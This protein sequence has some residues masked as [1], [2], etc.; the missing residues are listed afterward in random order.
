M[1]ACR[2]AKCLLL[3][4]ISSGRREGMRAERT[5]ARGLDRNVRPEKPRHTERSGDAGAA[6]Y[7]P[8]SGTDVLPAIRNPAAALPQNDSGAAGMPTARSPAD[9]LARR[10]FRSLWHAVSRGGTEKRRSGE[11]VRLCFRELRI[12]AAGQRTVTS[13]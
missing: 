9:R 5:S 6:A 2:D 13:A 12:P 4:R 8:L 1:M 11:K 7:M 3:C 10:R